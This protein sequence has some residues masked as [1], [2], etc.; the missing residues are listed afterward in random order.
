MSLLQTCVIEGCSRPTRYRG[1][2][3]KHWKLARIEEA[4]PQTAP[5]VDTATLA[6]AQQVQADRSK[7][8]VNA[9]LSSLRHKYNEALKTIERQEKEIGVVE[10]LRTGLDTYTI[11]ATKGSGTSEATPFVI[12]SDWHCEELVGKELGG[13]NVHTPEISKARVTRFFQASLRLIQLLNQDVTI[14]TVVLALLGDFITGNIHG[15]ENAEKNAMPPTEAIVFAQ[16]MIISGIEFWLAHSKYNLVIPCHSGNHART[17][18]TTRVATE[19]GHS[20][21]YLMYLHLEAYFRHEPRV[22]F[23]IAEGYHSYFEVYGRTVRFHHGHAAKYQGGVGGIYIPVNK[24]LDQ[25]DKARHADM[26]VFGHF[27][28]YISA[29]KFQCNGSVIGYNAFALSIKAAFERPQQS[30]F[31]VDKKR[32]RT[33]HWPV[34]VE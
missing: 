10:Q 28:Q 34:L 25:W 20:L 3:F 12:A 33:C 32:G 15:E 18:H 11:S 4:K 7:Q 5:E 30:L 21:E 2:C 14:N 26:D 23:R 17:T 13:L 8:R 29:P 31:L 24:A 19:N 1:L 6:S 16:N 27:H 9:E 22:T